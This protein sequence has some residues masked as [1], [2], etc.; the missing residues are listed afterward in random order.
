MSMHTVFSFVADSLVMF[1]FCI[2]DVKVLQCGL[3]N[4]SNGT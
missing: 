2:H 1:P 3:V 4:L